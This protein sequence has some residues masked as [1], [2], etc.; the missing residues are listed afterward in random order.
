MT[1]AK[2]SKRLEQLEQRQAQQAKVTDSRGDFIDKLFAQAERLI[3]SGHDLVHD[4]KESKFQNIAAAIARG[5]HETAREML[6]EAAKSMNER[7][8]A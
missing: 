3:Q 7:K 8:S 5:D 4:P 6:K 1:T 2:Q